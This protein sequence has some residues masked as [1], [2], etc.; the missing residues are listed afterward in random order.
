[1]IEVFKILNGFSVVSVDTFFAPNDDT[2]TRGH[3][4]KLLK[5]RCNKD[6]RHHFF[7]ERVVNRW[8]KLPSYTVDAKSVNHLNQLYKSYELLRSAFS[9]MCHHLPSLLS[10][11]I[12]WWTGGRPG[13]WPGKWVNGEDRGETIKSSLL[14]SSTGKLTTRLMMMMIIIIIITFYIAMRWTSITQELVRAR[15]RL[16]QRNLPGGG[17]S[18]DQGEQNLTLVM[19]IIIVIFVVCQS[20]AFGNQLLDYLIG[21]EQYACGKVSS[22]LLFLSAS[23]YVSKRGAYWDRLCRDVVGWLVVGRWLSRACTV[24]KRCIL[25]L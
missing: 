18:D 6:L 23:L 19:V 25:G 17:T 16:Q 1:M 7:S 21:D 13:K 9:W 4:R 3:S 2:R 14:R 15:R 5:R 12:V 11:F 8:N 10:S 20:P 24:A 22:T